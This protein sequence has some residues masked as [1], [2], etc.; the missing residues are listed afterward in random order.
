M[1]NDTERYREMLNIQM[2]S[3]DV[4]NYHLPPSYLLYLSLCMLFLGIAVGQ[5]WQSKALVVEDHGMHFMH[6]HAM[7]HEMININEVNPPAVS[8]SVAKDSMSGWNLRISLE[9]FSFAAE[10]VNQA[11]VAN[12]G[13]AHLY[14]DG[15]KQAR[16]YGPDYHFSD[17]PLGKHTITVTLNANNHAALAI[18]NQ[19][20]ESSV[21][22]E[23]VDNKRPN[24]P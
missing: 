23:Q 5:Q 10:S 12:E 8:L 20:I 17:L 15:V 19:I 6:D 1:A 18:D 24:T 3:E 16:L 22:I 4:E 2:K 7:T 13:H 21:I 11:I 14:I 9:N